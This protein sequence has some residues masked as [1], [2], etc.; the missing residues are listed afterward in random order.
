MSKIKA[1]IFDFDGVLVES[2]DIKT[3]AFAHLFREYPESVDRIVRFH[4]AHG[5]ISRFE[6]FE[7]IHK[8][9]LMTPLS[10]GRKEELGK[11][12]SDFVYKE[13]VRCP[14]VRGAK[15]F[16]EKHHG[17]Y[18]FFVV[19]GTPDE[20][21]KAIV[22]ERGLEKYF[23]EVLGSPVKKAAHNRSII[24]KYRLKP[25]ETLFVGDSIDDYKGARDAGIGFV[26]RMTG[27][28]TFKGLDVYAVI[29]DV[30]GL[31]KALNG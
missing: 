24:K 25:G 6:K 26:G 28:N 21:I 13:V 17:K 1:I 12:F 15:E 18:L 16:L 20:E 10:P 23:A 14:F 29:K 30:R 19:S 2:L 11:L 7:I 5:G 22:K 4:A 9:I 31:E 27:G 3:R 8:D